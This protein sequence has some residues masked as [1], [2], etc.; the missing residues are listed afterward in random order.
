MPDQETL[1]QATYI[2]SWTRIREQVTSNVL[3]AITLSV[4]SGVLALML[5][6][7]QRLAGYIVIP[8]NILMAI[9][10]L[11]GGALL[12]LLTIAG[13]LYVIIR[14]ALLNEKTGLAL[15]MGITAFLVV[16][17]WAQGIDFTKARGATSNGDTPKQATD[18]PKGGLHRDKEAAPSAAHD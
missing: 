2:L 3:S 7:Y 16:L 5:L 12:T 10:F 11:G 18:S 13:M 6:V 8:T 14:R 17:G 15:M 9:V 1:K 4:L